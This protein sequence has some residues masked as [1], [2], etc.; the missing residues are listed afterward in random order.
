MTWLSGNFYDIMMYGSERACLKKWR[1]ALLQNASGKVLEIGAG[2]GVNL[3]LY[4]EKVT[5]LT[6]IEPDPKMR[7]VLARRIQEKKTIQLIDSTVE[8][9]P[10]KENS[11]DFVVSTLV[12][13]SVNDVEKSLS[14]IHRVLRPKGKLLFLEHVAAEEIDHFASYL[15]QKLNFIWK[16]ASAGCQLVR[17]TEASIRSSNFEIEEITREHLCAFAKL[18]WPSV[19]GIARKITID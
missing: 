12:L 16:R 11:F 10:F 15:Q 18:L 3:T 4:P 14:E 5:S 13:C 17:T 7:R 19:R 1:R 2:T 6:L 9:L 8:K